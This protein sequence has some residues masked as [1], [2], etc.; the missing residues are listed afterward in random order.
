MDEALDQLKPPP[1]EPPP[2]IPAAPSAAAPAPPAA[3]PPLQPPPRLEPPPPLGPPPSAAPST[4]APTPTAAPQA[5]PS[6]DAAPVAEAGAP[7][8][9]ESPPEPGGQEQTPPALEPPP[10]LETHGIAYLPPEPAPPPKPR[11][12]MSGKTKAVIVG[13][14][15]GAILATGWHFAVQAVKVDPSPAVVVLVTDPPGEVQA[16]DAVLGETPMKITDEL[17]RVNVVKEGYYP[18]LVKLKFEPNK[19]VRMEQ[20]LEPIVGEVDLQG[21]P[22]TAKISLNGGEPKALKDL[23][24]HWPVG[25]YEVAVQVPYQEPIEFSVEIVEGKTTKVGQLVKDAMA[26]RPQLIL[27]VPSVQNYTVTLIPAGGGP[28]KEA[29][30]TGKVHVELDAPG[31]YELRVSA[32]GYHTEVRTLTIQGPKR[33]AVILRQRAGVAPPP[34]PPPPAGGAGPAFPPAPAPAPAPSSGGGDHK[35][36]APTF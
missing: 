14:L 31:K 35:I 9:A 22:L 29:S 2:P 11:K 32:E 28:A 21:V 4:A 33:L 13:L 36:P 10:P 23:T 24:H 17:P 5:P 26:S 3:P 34:P 8:G 15:C 19:V 12:P 27:S 25:K 20:K 16:G 1:L 18:L 7:A 6:G 30:G